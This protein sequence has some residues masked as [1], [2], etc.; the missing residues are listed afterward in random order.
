MKRVLMISIAI[1]A[2]VYGVDFARFIFGRQ[3]A[4]GVLNSV[5]VQRYYA[6]KLKNGKTEY[7]FDKPVLESC[8]ECLFPHRGYSPCWYLRR[9]PRKRL[10]M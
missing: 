4:G 6:V 3:R 5:E 2:A 7:M 9:N 1:F 8:A 10:D